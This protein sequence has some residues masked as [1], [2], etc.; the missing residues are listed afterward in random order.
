MCF[1]R[2]S[3]YGNK[4]ISINA[5]NLQK[6]S[7]HYLTSSLFPQPYA[8][9]GNQLF[10]AASIYAIGRRLNR[11]PFI[12]LNEMTENHKAKLV[13]MISLFPRFAESIYRHR[14][15]IN[16]SELTIVSFGDHF[17]KYAPIESL[18]AH[19]E[20]KYLYLTGEYFQSWKYF[21]RY[22][23]ELM[24]M[25]ES[26]E[27]DRKESI[28]LAENTFGND[29]S[30]KLCVHIRREDFLENDIMQHSTQTFMKYSIEFL[31]KYYL[32]NYSIVLMGMD[33]NWLNEFMKTI[34]IDG[35]GRVYNRKITSNNRGETIDFAFARSYCNAM[36]L[37]ATAS[38]F[39]W[40]LAY[41]S[42]AENV[43]FN[44]KFLKDTASDD[45]RNAISFVDYILPNY[46]ALYYNESENRIT[47]NQIKEF[48]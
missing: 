11:T 37:T 4:N 46:V 33:Y 14:F 31:S 35:G 1:S 32:H 48:L 21:D 30:K 23:S 42:K 25:L 44:Q 36:L 18:L 41:L 29:R 12:N 16:K 7:S 43:Y 24:H 17:A 20:V 5:I 28:K 13:T 10:I 15:A 34:N 6:L 2:N 39:G 27:F 9:V 19:R 45:Y 38:T 8:G 22:K 40:W 47:M 3:T 26:N